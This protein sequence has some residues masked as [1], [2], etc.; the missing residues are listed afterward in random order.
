MKTSVHH[1]INLY[2]SLNLEEQL[3]VLQLLIHKISLSTEHNKSV[4]NSQNLL[5]LAGSG[6]GIY[7]DVDD[8]LASERDWN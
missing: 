4:D 7:G 5:S 2:S 3:A 1:I 6:K 8:Y